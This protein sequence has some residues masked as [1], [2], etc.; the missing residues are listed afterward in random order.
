MKVNL[1]IQSTG[2]AGRT[3]WR[4]SIL[5]VVFLMGLSAC[6]GVQAPG[7]A[8]AGNYGIANTGAK[9]TAMPKAMPTAMPANTATAQPAAKSASPKAYIGLFKD[10]AVAVLDTGTDQVIKT[11][12]VPAGPHGLVITPDGRWVYISSDGDT[13]VSVID[14]ASDTVVKSIEVG[15]MP[16]GLAL[17]P[18][19]KMLLAA[20]FGTNQV[21]FLDTSSGQVVGQVSVPSPHNIAISPDG[22]S[23]YVAA[24]KKGAA[25]LSVIDIGEKKQDTFI[26]LDKA[27]RALNFSPDGKLLYFTQAGVDAVQVLNPATNQVTGQIAVGASPHQPLFLPDDSMALVVSQGPGELDFLSPETGVS[28]L[29]LAVG[30]MPHWIAVNPEGTKAWVTNEG[31]N[32]VSVVDLNKFTVTAT[33]PVGNAPRKMVVQPGMPAAAQTPTASPAANTVAIAGMAFSPDSITIKAGQTISWTNQDSITHT[34]TD[35]QGGWDSGPL[36]PGKSYS[37]TFAKPGQYTY[38]CSIHPFMTGKIIVTQ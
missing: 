33:I 17:T 12:P 32:T 7:S 16:H 23:A 5:I 34:V 30:K 27:P 29:N 35:D 24:Q 11:I 36:A 18:D 10:N 8:N 37:Q 6:T 14:T 1:H 28:F 26:P 25:G 2:L 38:H 9:A 3:A 15:K 20:V 22:Y 13:K 31:S 21:V 19:G 4:L